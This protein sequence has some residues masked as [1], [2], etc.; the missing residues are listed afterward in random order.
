[1]YDLDK[2]ESFKS[3]FSS[4]Q[5][6]VKRD[7]TGIISIGMSVLSFF[8]QYQMSN[9]LDSMKTR[10]NLFARQLVSVTNTSAKNYKNAKL[11]RGATELMETDILSLRQINRLEALILRTQSES[12]SLFAGLEALL[13]G[14]LSL[15][16]VSEK[17][18]SRE[19]YSFRAACLD[20]D[21]MPLFPDSMQ[22]FQVPA[23]FM[24]E[25]GIIQAVV[26]LPIVPV[27]FSDPFVVYR[28]RPVP[29][30]LGGRLAMVT[31]SSD[32]V[33]LSPDYSS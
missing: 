14:R 21:F 6:L 9:T 26:N 8:T 28:Y 18:V 10:Q 27:K 4:N 24:Y 3:L 11:L 5:K 31:A 2:L 7:V 13:S 19:F 1:M 29:V 23:S 25:D 16:L 12:R 20:K 33:A 17:E 30:L 22:V 15:L 32:L